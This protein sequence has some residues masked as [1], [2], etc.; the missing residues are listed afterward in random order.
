MTDISSQSVNWS[1]LAIQGRI[2]TR[3][4]NQVWLQVVGLGS[5]S[6]AILMLFT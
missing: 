6:I 5:M 2:K 3:N 1:S 4:R